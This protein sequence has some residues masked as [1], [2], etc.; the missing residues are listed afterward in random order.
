MYSC[1]E[2]FHGHRRVFLCVTVFVVIFS[3]VYEYFGHGVKSNAMLYAFLFPGLLGLLPTVI[4]G[5]TGAMRRTAYAGGIRVAVNL[6]Y[7]G[8]ATLTVGALLFGVVEIYGTTYH[9][10]KYYYYV[11]F[12]LAAAGIILGIIAFVFGRYEM[13]RRK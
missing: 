5:C 3:L 12:G 10:L 9:L 4:L 1:A 7:C 13:E 6:W 8:I 11:G 2:I